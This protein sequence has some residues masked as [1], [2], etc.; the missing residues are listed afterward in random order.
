M[1]LARLSTR[2]L[3]IRGPCFSTYLFHCSLG[4]IQAWIQQKVRVGSS[5]YFLSRRRDR[6]LLLSGYGI[7]SNL[8][9]PLYHIGCLQ[10][11]WIAAIDCA[12]CWSFIP[13][14]S[15]SI[16]L[17]LELLNITIVSSSSD[18]KHYRCNEKLQRYPCW[19]NKF[20]VQDWGGYY[21]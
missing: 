5:G 3:P 8:D 12:V 1:R 14:V 9:E 17:S 11:D 21:S 2:Y 20:T 4:I 15:R 10:L 6:F 7:Q 13:G 19:Y 16:S 18:S